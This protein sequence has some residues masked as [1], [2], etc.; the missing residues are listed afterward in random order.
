ML[1]TFSNL[2]LTGLGPGTTG[3]AGI[4]AG[5]E[6][7]APTGVQ[8][9]TGNDVMWPDDGA[10]RWRVSNN[11]GPPQDILTGAARSDVLKFGRIAARSCA[12]RNI[13]IQGA[14]MSELA[15]ANPE[16]DPGR[17]FA[18][19]TRVIADNKVAVRLCNQEANSETPPNLTWVVGAAE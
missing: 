12:E 4:I 6:G 5:R 2:N 10:H 17:N 3:P 15:W 13:T 8:V 14:R 18:W 16:G 19:Q 7:Y 9:K 11:G 1:G